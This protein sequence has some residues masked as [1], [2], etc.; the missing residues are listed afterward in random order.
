MKKILLVRSNKSYL[1]Q[2]DASIDYFNG[3]E[4]GF[5]LYDSAELSDISLSEFDCLWEFMGFNMSKKIDIPLIHEYA[6]LSTGVFPRMK[7][8]G[9][10]WLN[11]KPDLRI[12]LNE[13]VS[14]GLGFNDKTD[15]VYRDMGVDDVF[16]NYKQ[17]SKTYDCVYIGSITKE[18]GTP[19]L[20][21]Q[22]KFTCKNRSLLLIGKVSD[23]IYKNYSS[24]DNI[25]FAGELPYKEVPQYASQAI[26]GINYMPNK[27]PY[28][29]QTSTKL[30]EY[31]AM[32]LEVITTDYLWIHH[33]MRENKI[34][35]IMVNEKLDGLEKAIKDH[36]GKSAEREMGTLEKF[37]W[38]HVIEQSGLEEKLLNIL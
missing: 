9:K 27:Y 31:L 8:K 22:F 29:L 4:L 18:R 28:N 33:F 11:V 17:S 25:T 19:Y 26:Y 7:N 5:Q 12:Y 2:I 13:Y 10:K 36:E 16:F 1:P 30:L 6:S 34:N 21:D 35:F 38:K 20:L 14:E 24:C 37:K 15:Y 23:E 3:K 32:G